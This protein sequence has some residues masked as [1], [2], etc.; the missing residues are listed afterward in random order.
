MSCSPEASK[1]SGYHEI[2]IWNASNGTLVRRI[3]DVAER[4]FD[5]AVSPDGQWLAAASG[6][7]AKLGEVKLFAWSNG[8]PARV[9]AASADAQLC[10]AF[11]PDG[12]RLAAG[13]ADNTIRL[14]DLTTNAPSIVVEQNADWVLSIAFSPDSTR[15]VSASRDKASRIF[16]TTTG[17]LDETYTGH[18]DF[19]LS[20]VWAD[21]KSVVSASRPREVHRWNVK[22]AKKN[23]DFKGWDAEV[24]RLIVAGTNLFSAA[25]DGKVRQHVL[26]AKVLART[27]EAHGD[28]VHALAL[29][30]KTQRLASGSHDGEVRVWDTEGELLRKFVAAPGYTRKLTRAP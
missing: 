10:V 15:F 23:A 25:L 7:P 30:E 4:T 5:L 22:D 14:W 8:E 24:T 16:S 18:G 27:F 3:G 29:H 1:A 13:G 21:D 11:S 6:T 12:K 17:E 20:A 28:V 2:T 26:P 9:L 19:V